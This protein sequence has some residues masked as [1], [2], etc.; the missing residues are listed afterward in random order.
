MARPAHTP[1]TDLVQKPALGFWQ[2]WNMGFG[3]LGIQIGFALQNGNV[4]RI[5]ETLGAKPDE[6]PLYWLAGPITGLLVQPIVGYLSDRT[7]GPLGRR[8]PY[9][10]AGAILTALALLVMPNSPVLWVA[11]GTLWL[12]DA[13]LNITMEPFRAFVGDKLPSRQ[14]PAGYALQ[15]VFIGTGAVLASLAPILF[16][17]SGVSN[18]SVNGAIPQNVQLSFYVGAACL[19]AAVLWTVIS[20]PEYSP[21][22]VEKFAPDA[23]NI[24]YGADGPAEAAAPAASQFSRWGLIALALGAVLSF[25]V[26][27][28]GA[29]QQFYILTGGLVAMGALLLWYSTR[30]GRGEPG[31]VG[32]ILNDLSTMPEV[33]KRLALVQFC[34]WFGLFLMWNF[35]TRVVAA[36]GWGAMDSDAPGF[37]DAGDWVGVLFA[38]Q[39]GV[40]AIY[41]FLI[42]G[43]AHRFGTRRMHMLNLLAGAAGFVGLVLVQDKYLMILPMI[44]LGMAWGS[45]LCLPYA[46]LADALPARKLG[47]YMGIFNFFI[48]LPQILVGAGAGP[49]LRSVEGTLAPLVGGVAHLG[50]LA[51]GVVMALGAAAMLRVVAPKRAA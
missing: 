4:S 25:A 28:F 48:V 26:W 18:E 7:W 42:A 45:I 35:T 17:S 36:N 33:M 6:L 15:T 29:D 50:L 9:F 49:V 11:V 44:G 23:D 40:A 24:F 30:A 19:L 10:L 47:I 34:S 38:V 1:T 8:R 14:R 27:R 46:L 2:L 16:T 31:M 3:F 39:N 13:S 21:A 22:E 43:L 41:A 12:L 37:Q 32:H 20:T 51:A 5:F